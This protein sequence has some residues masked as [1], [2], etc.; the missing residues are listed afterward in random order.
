MKLE[1]IVACQINDSSLILETM[2]VLLWDV[3][4]L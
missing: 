2:D 3:D 4:K 1:F